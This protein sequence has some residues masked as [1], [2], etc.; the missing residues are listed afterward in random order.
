MNTVLTVRR[1]DALGHL[2][3][4]LGPL[5]LAASARGLAGVW[6]DGQAHHPGPLET[7][8]AKAAQRD[9][10]LAHIA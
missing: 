9:A 8:A 7:A 1:F 6:F 4:P 2:D 5:R 10:A 3:T